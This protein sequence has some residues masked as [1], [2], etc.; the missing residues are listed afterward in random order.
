MPALTERA[1]RATP[2]SVDVPAAAR[3]SAPRRVGIVLVV[4]VLLAIVAA[5][6]LWGLSR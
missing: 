3:R 1:R 5:L 4:L 2:E 6:A